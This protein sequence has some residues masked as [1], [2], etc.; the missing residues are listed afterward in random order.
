MADGRNVFFDNNGTKNF[1]KG[2]RVP[3]DIYKITLSISIFAE[4]PRLS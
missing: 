3:H 1:G 4:E 2:V